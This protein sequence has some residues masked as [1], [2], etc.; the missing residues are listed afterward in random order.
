MFDAGRIR[1]NIRVQNARQEQ[2]LAAYEKAVLTAL[3]EAENA[4]V[5]YAREQNRL[6]SLDQAVTAAGAALTLAKDL[7]TQ[8]LTDY[9]RVL[10][11]ERSVASAEA[12]RAQ[13]RAAVLIHLAALY[14][15]LGGG[16]NPED[17]EPAAAPAR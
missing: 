5:A 12:Q 9:L 14:K 16:W 13:S 17:A 11:A 2:A 6:A 3:E 7:H 15:A 10:D 1:A 8:G 4:L